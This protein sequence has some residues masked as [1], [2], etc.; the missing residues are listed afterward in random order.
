MYT[1]MILSIYD[2]VNTDIKNL[3]FIILSR[4]LKVR[5]KNYKK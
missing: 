1:N 2:F 3:F 4:L 5:V